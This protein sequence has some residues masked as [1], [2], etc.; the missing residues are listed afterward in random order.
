MSIP[1]KARETALRMLFQWE[2]SKEPPEKTRETYWANAKADLPMREFAD[3]LFEGVI[4]WRE[5]IDSL[6]TAHSKHWRLERMSLVDRNI[7][8]VGIC[9]FLTRPD[10]S[11]TIVITEAAEVARDYSTDASAEFIQATLDSI[12]RELGK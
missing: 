1:R 2:M 9:E 6:I 4:E 5:T 10:V 7:L 11:A 3:K 12:R 8:R